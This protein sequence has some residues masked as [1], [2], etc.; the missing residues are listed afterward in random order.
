MIKMDKLPSGKIAIANKYIAIFFSLSYLASR[1]REI[2]EPK[3]L[4]ASFRS[5]AKNIM[6]LGKMLSSLFF[7]H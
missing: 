2:P 7:I 1:L 4:G 3:A 6:G 5:P